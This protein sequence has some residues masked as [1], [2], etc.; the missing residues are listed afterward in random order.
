M[1]QFGWG[2]AG[3]AELEC[4]VRDP[5]S[6]DLPS[7]EDI[8][9][10]RQ[11]LSAVEGYSS[12]SEILNRRSGAIIVKPHF[13]DKA[14]KWHRG[15]PRRATTHGAGLLACLWAFLDKARCSKPRCANEIIEHVVAGPSHRRW[16]RPN[17]QKA[18]SGVSFFSRHDDVP[19]GTEKRQFPDT[20]GRRIPKFRVRKRNE[21]S[22]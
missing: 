7:K 14:L 20:T 11:L 6:Q 9:M 17:P 13:S 5:I 10:L 4:W 1:M 18:L 15:H 2:W 22:Q 12:A 8:S 16:S 21:K 19:R 3:L